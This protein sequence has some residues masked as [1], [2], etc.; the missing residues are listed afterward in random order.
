MSCGLDA[1]IRENR[2]DLTAYA[3]T[4]AGNV[5]IG[6]HA[7][8]SAVVQ[9]YENHLRS[10]SLCPDESELIEWIKTLVAR[11]IFNGNWASAPWSRRDRDAMI[12]TLHWGYGL[13]CK[14]IGEILDWPL[15][16]V[17]ASVGRTAMWHLR[18]ARSTQKETLANIS[19]YLGPVKD[20]VQ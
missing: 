5:T 19:E 20:A 6:E 14:R 3:A 7:A 12:A 10:G 18:G 11:Q 4:L 16:K 17:L 1:V 8:S 13:D 9:T 15:A 2:Q